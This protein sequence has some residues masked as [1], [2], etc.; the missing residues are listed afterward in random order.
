MFNN[1][2]LITKVVI[3]LIITIHKLN[4]IVVNRFAKLGMGNYFHV[5]G[6]LV[7]MDLW[8]LTDYSAQE[9]GKLKCKGLKTR[10]KMLEIKCTISKQL[11]L[12]NI[13]IHYFNIH[14]KYLCKIINQKKQ[15]DMKK[16]LVVLILSVMTA[17][18][19]SAQTGQSKWTFN[20]R[21]WTTNYWTSMIFGLAE[22]SVKHFLFNG[23]K[24]DSLWAERLI[25][26]PDLV[27]PIGMSK[28]GFEKG[29]NN[30]YGPY[31]HAF[32]SPF[33]HIGD[34]AIGI[35]A[36]YKPSSVGFYAGAY[37]KSQ[38]IHYKGSNAVMQ[39]S[40]RGYY[41]QP[42]AGIV[43]GGDNHQFEAGVFYDAVTGCGGSL[44]T[45]EKDML[46]SGFG[47]DFGLSHSDGNTRYILQF[48]MPLH[49]FLNKD[50]PGQQ[51]MKRK[52]GYIMFT[53]RV[54]L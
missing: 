14:F 32:G 18:N 48:S 25:P 23:D 24:A 22:T 34:Y 38:E 17:T 10:V 12:F 52:V 20:T 33:K 15:K 54:Y 1:N 41:I 27:F 8:L 29:V 4:K 13:N 40:L 3:F 2:D 11:T 9:M 47:L 49:N 44:K 21:A 16:I 42:R 46:E 43:V 30:I 26:D 5:A 6:D 45:G 51:G 31:H 50:F 37:F 36:S 19:M 35:D 7:F 28:Q 39:G 53:Q